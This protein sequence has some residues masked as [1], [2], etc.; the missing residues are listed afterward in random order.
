MGEKI[1]AFTESE[2]H[3]VLA[4][5][6]AGVTTERQLAITLEVAIN[7]GSI[8]IG[9]IHVAGKYFLLKSSKGNQWN[10]IQ[11]LYYT[12]KGNVSIAWSNRS[13]EN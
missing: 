10:K 7:S 1:I 6:W 4:M 13:F 11:M 8:T 5:L 9:E 2:W 3:P 12:E